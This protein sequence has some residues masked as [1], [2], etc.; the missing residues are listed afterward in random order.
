MHSHQD[1]LLKAQEP[2]QA[3]HCMTGASIASS[4]PP[5]QSHT[6]LPRTSSLPAAL[7]YLPLYKQSSRSCPC[8]SARAVPS[9]WNSPLLL[10]NHNYCLLS[11]YCMLCPLHM[12]LSLNPQTN[13]MENLSLSQFKNK[14]NKA[15]RIK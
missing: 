1:D 13:H 4:Q 2:L 3:L 8:V 11:I 7:R 9:A 14:E 10:N 5:S 15:Q 6:S 12:Y